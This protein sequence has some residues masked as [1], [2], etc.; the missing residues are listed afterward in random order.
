MLEELGHDL[1]QVALAGVGAITILLEK[2]G[3]FAQECISK[4]A[5]T[6]EKGR[7][8]TE[9]LRIKAEQAAK[10]RKERCDEENL[11]RMTQEERDALRAKLD[12][13]DKLEAEAAAQEDVE[14]PDTSGE[15][16]EP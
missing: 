15:D 5:T 4:G 2:G 12:E 9:D 13:L 11:S 1:K 8:V 16:Q 7:E 14:T 10:E 3:E 6:V